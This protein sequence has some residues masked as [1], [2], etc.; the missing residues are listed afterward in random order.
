MDNF[1]RKSCKLQAK[2]GAERRVKKMWGRAEEAAPPSC[3]FCQKIVCLP[4]T[5]VSAWL[6]R[7]HCCWRALLLH[8]VGSF[9]PSSCVHCAAP[10]FNII[11]GRQSCFYDTHCKWRVLWFLQRE[12]SERE[13]V[14]ESSWVTVCIC[15]GC[16]ALCTSI[17]AALALSL[18]LSL[19]AL[20]LPLSLTFCC[21]LL[22]A[23]H[24]LPSAL[25]ALLP[26]PCFA[27]SL[28]FT[29]CTPLSARQCPTFSFLLLL[30]SASY[31][32]QSN[33][34]HVKCCSFFLVVVACR[35][36]VVVVFVVAV[37]ACIIMASI[38]FRCVM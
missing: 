6:E 9:L 2:N 3:H 16:I 12:W 23:L 4:A 30:L 7:Q 25:C 1:G 17:A 20:H 28:F 26:A 22:C 35:R 11:C 15:F 37:S 36:V 14:G 31:L 13:R 29:L 34:T 27:L 19:F 24:F 21:S 38:H 8:L 5:D 10:S 32:R 33:Q 18:S